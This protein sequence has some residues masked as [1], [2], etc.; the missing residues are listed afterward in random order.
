[1]FLD[2][3]FVDTPQIFE[4]SPIVITP[5]LLPFIY[6]LYP[7]YTFPLGQSQLP[8]TY[9][10]KKHFLQ[11]KKA[12]AN[13]ALATA[14]PLLIKERYIF[15]RIFTSCRVM[16][17]FQSNIFRSCHSFSIERK[18]GILSILRK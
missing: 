10:H 7:L 9:L 13:D 8:L 5:F 1:M 14:R 11:N 6:V 16:F 15:R 3:H 17:G 2:P 18:M 12:V 4:N